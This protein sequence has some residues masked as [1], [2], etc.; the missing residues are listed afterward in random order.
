MKLTYYAPLLPV[1]NAVMEIASRNGN[2]LS[3]VTGEVCWHPVMEKRKNQYGGFDPGSEPHYVY[4]RA[5][6]ILEVLEHPRGPSFRIT[7]DPIL[8]KAA[9]EAKRC[10]KGF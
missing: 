5:N 10:D 6:G 2:T 7:D 4:I 8:V 1:D 9:V 3:M